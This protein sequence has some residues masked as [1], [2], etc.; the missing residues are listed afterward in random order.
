MEFDLNKKYCYYFKQI[1]DIPRG[2]RN[3]KAVSDYV[4]AFAKQRGYD[5]IQDDVYNVI[6]NKPASKGYE[7]AEPVILQAHMDMVCEKNKDIEHDFNKDPLDLYVD[8]EG[9]LRARGTTLGADDGQGVA[10]MLAILDDPNL[11][12]PELQ[13]A[14]TVME[15][16][17]LYG[18]IAL[19]KEYFHARRYINL[20]SGGENQTCVT[21][22]GGA[23]AVISRDI[24]FK[25]NGNPCYRIEIRGLKG[26]HSAGCI[27][28]ER[29]NAIILAAR[30]LQA[31]TVSFD[32]I[33]LI[34]INGGMKFNAIPRECDILFS[35]SAAPEAL[36]ECASK[37]F[38]DIEAELR[39]SDE[40][41]KGFLRQADQ[42][43]QAISSEE[44]KQIADFLYIIP[45]GLYHRS[46]VI[47]GLSVASLN[48]GVIYIEDGTLFVDDLLRSAAPS[49]GDIM[50]TQLEILSPQF[51]FRFELHDRYYGWDYVKESPLR[52]ILRQVLKEK[53]IEMQERATHGGLECGIFK[54]LIPDLDIITYGPISS[55]E[56]TPE[57]KLDL[58]SFDR[59]YEN[60]LA[61]LERCK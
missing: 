44:T 57:E 19:K 51:G 38:A 46:M 55:G 1:S 27:H 7:N 26:G 36:T 29:G 60:L 48:L 53:G 13:C 18:A 28:L 24:S 16:I 33:R 20:D 41:F 30:V 49:H 52:E 34:D 35:S 42:S 56:H 5:Y 45:N 6:V 50:I 17:G 2:S 39:Y 3:E 22:S 15:E 37:I 9:W 10:Y 11:K 31:M 12:H 54:G 47:E 21:S 61:V 25:T 14:F 58:A 8:E 23:R 32:D 59:A 40:G 4:V 43:S